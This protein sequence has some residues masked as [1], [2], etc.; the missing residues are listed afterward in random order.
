M[1]L[2]GAVNSDIIVLRVVYDP[3]AFH[4]E[5]KTYLDLNYRTHSCNFDYSTVTTI[6]KDDEPTRVC[7]V[8]YF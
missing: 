4:F 8:R 5:L 2:F 3:N 7:L 6:I 1:L